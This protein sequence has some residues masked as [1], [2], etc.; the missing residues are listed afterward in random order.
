MVDVLACSRAVLES[1]D[2]RFDQLKHVYVFLFSTKIKIK[3]NIRFSVR[4]III[5]MSLENEF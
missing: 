4:Y 5:S 3:Y 1:F 2:K